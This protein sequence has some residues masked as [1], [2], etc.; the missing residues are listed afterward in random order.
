MARLVPYC[1]ENLFR[2]CNRYW[3]ELGT[4]ASKHRAYTS[5]EMMLCA[6]DILN[7]LIFAIRPSG[8]PPTPSLSQSHPHF[9][10]LGPAEVP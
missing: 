7:A 5:T 3:V 4:A 8:E 2:L 6:P 1:K 10:D 9:G